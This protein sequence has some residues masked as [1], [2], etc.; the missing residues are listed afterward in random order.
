MEKDYKDL[1]LKREIQL[2]VAQAE[3]ATLLGHQSTFLTYGCSSSP[4]STHNQ[5]THSSW[6]SSSLSLR[7]FQL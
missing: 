7:F 3:E 4:H 5:M 6:N 1:K 2:K